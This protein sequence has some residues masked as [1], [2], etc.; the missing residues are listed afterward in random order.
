MSR[1]GTGDTYVVKAANN[2][3][4]VLTFVAFLAAALA[5]IVVMMK[6]KA[7]FDAGLF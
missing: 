4:T 3:Y 5:V 2:V 1:V 6:S 7:L